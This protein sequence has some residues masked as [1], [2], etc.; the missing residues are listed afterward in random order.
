MGVRI[1]IYRTESKND[2]EEIKLYIS[3]SDR[4]ERE[5]RE[6]IISTKQYFDLRQPT[7]EISIEK[8]EQIEEAAETWRAIKKGMGILLYSD[9]SAH[10]LKMKL[11]ALGYSSE[12]AESAVK[13]LEA[14]GLVDEKK[15]VRR[16]FEA[17]LKKGHGRRRIEADMMKKGI[18]KDLIEDFNLFDEIDYA[19][20]CAIVIE[21]KWG[22]FPKEK[23]ERDRAVRSLLSLGY[24]FDDINS[25]A[26][27]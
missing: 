1:N 8:F 21:K 15:M 11:G 16:I 2:G 26:R 23:K 4:Y 5:D 25:A 27:K 24:T 14:L 7:D 10:R 17:G 9:N 20:R 3:L 12:S 18:R 19:E 6:V 13:Y 22:E